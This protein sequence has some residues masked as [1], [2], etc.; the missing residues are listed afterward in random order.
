[1][2]S[3]AIDTPPSSE[4][5]IQRRAF[6]LFDAYVRLPRWWRARK[7]ARLAESDPALHGALSALLDADRRGDVIADAP[8]PAIAGLLEAQA[9]EPEADPR[10]GARIGAWE[11]I[12]VLGRG[13][14]GTVYRARRCDAQLRQIV[15]LKCI[16][17]DLVS[18]RLVEAFLAERNMLADLTHPDIVPLLDGG[19][20]D[21]GRPWYAMPLVDGLAIDQWCD[22]NA[23]SIR[24][25]V[26][27]FV[28]ACGQVAYAHQRGLVHQDIKPSNLLV[29]S[30][31]RPRLLDFGL[32]MLLSSDVLTT[33]QRLAMTSGYTAPEALASGSQDVRVDVYAL[34]V[35]LCRLLCGDGP[36]VGPLA[37]G[38]P[39]AP[40]SWVAKLDASAIRARAA[41]SAAGL[42]R[43]LRGPLDAI[44]LRAV[45]TA[46]DQRFASVDA[47][48]DALTAWLGRTGPASVS[49]MKRVLMP[50]GAVLAMAVVGLLGGHLWRGSR[51]AA[52]ASQADRFFESM[53][54][55]AAVSEL[56][57][58]P[59]TR[60]ALLVSLEQGLR[61][62][63][64]GD[65]ADGMGARGLSVLARGWAVAGDYRRAEALAREAAQ[66]IGPRDPLAA[67]FN[68]ATLAQIQ[69]LQ[70]QHADAEVT[71][72]AG[73][74]RL[75]VRL[76]DQHRL[77][78]L[79]LLAQRA[80]A[81]SGQGRSQAAFATLDQAIGEA[82]RLPPAVA[83]NITAQL[84]TQ[85]GI[86]LRWRMRMQ[87]SEADLLRAIA[88]TDDTAPIL[89]DDARESLIRTVRASR[90]PG[91]EQRAL[92]LANQLIERRRA[93]LGERHPQ[94]GMALAELAFIQILNADLAGASETA[95]QAERILAEALGADHPAVARAYMAQ[96]HLAAYARDMP[97][98]FERTGRALRIYQRHYGP[99]QEF[100]LEARFLMASHL[101]ARAGDGADDPDLIRARDT[102]GAAIASSVAAHG[103]VSAHHR[104]GYAMLL[105]T[106]GRK[107]EAA[108][109]LV[110][111]KRDAARQFGPDSQDAMMV[112]LAEC[113][114]L[115]RY[116]E[117]D[118]D[119]LAALTGLERDA[120]ATG[121][122][123]AD[124]VLHSVLAMQA[125]WLLE[126]QRPNEALDA[127]QRGRAIA[128]KLDKPGL[129]ADSDAMI[130][131]VRAAHRSDAAPVDRTAA[132]SP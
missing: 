28:E 96:G 91:R 1:M 23:L 122:M 24:A 3:S 54:G 126:R 43:Q 21:A 58:L 128:I 66:M 99:D 42:A 72:R 69:N 106:T 26:A 67:A 76:T 63:A 40:S 7:L 103:D 64:V 39:R 17:D 2:R 20:D 125:R 32:S 65:D 12:G 98:A 35:L 5:A 15:A 119:T 130:D 101:W 87:E 132:R 57:D 93:T 102:L 46:P 71:V 11:I 121:T 62:Q 90:Q 83:D 19:V 33:S 37:S 115:V 81:E 8:F 61:R 34:G 120:A 79:R 124:G 100:T 85:R 10:I 41:S 92:A 86:W 55:M 36:C 70:A 80:V 89:A 110:L 78:H 53:L 131:T 14:M 68:L 74:A 51:E 56:G 107:A 88:L 44:V 22:A 105:A 18:L 127:A 60:S 114:F 29:T 75:P 118:T 48:T 113:G 123:F 9:E 30:Q 73:L 4:P 104:G 116:G 77:A 25:R 95:D 52:V 108:R 117:N 50:A 111:G 47:L 13:G 112:R 109:Q 45:A 97:R 94:T 31:G 27:L 38:P 129:I 59:P 16:R 82:G 49:R 84:L 6:D